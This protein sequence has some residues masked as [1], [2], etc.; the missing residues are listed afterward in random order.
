[1]A[2]GNPA[3]EQLAAV[4]AEQVADRTRV[5]EPQQL[6]VDA[7][8]KRRAPADEKQSPARALAL[9]AHDYIAKPFDVEKLLSEVER[10]LKPRTTPEVTLPS[11]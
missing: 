8:F 7:M 6:R 10:L 11:H 4:T 9:G 2:A 5:P 3:A 1:M